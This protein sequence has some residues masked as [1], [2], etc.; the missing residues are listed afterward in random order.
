[1]T[2]VTFS[3]DITPT[4]Y[5]LLGHPPTAASPVLGRSMLR[6]VAEASAD[7]WQLLASSYGAVYG[8]LHGNGR[9][10]YI[11]DAVNYQDYYYDIERDPEGTKNLVTPDVRREQQAHVREGVANINRFYKIAEPAGH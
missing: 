4:L 3:T 1:P 2:D 10:L 6:R 8:T 11:V 5:E 7:D 9:W